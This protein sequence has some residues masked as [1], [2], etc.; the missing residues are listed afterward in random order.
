[1]QL[2]VAVSALR[3]CWGLF[4]AVGLVIILC[5]LTSPLHISGILKKFEEE[6]LDDVLVR[7]LKDSTETPGAL[8]HIYAGEDA[9]K[10]REFLQKVCAASV[11]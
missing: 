9:D 3:S 6:D 8:W 7:R 10:I 5:G 1:M 2:S 4:V 11:P